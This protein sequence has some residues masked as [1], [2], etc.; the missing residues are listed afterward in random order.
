MGSALYSYC[1]GFCQD[2]D[3]FAQSRQTQINVAQFQQMLGRHLI[4][5][6][7]FFTAGQIAQIK[8]GSL[9]H[10]VLVDMVH[11]DQELKQYMASARSYIHLR[12]P[13]DPVALPAA[14]QGEAVGGRRH[15]VLS[16]SLNVD[17]SVLVLANGQRCSR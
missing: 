13:L 17:A 14:Q 5:L 7:D 16:Q 4:I 3:N 8:L 1:A 6:I 2:V 12:R 15:H 9:Q 11:L 10:A